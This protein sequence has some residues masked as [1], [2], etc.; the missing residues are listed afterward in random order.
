MGK[1]A[2]LLGII[3]VA[4]TGLIAYTVVY[5]PSYRQVQLIQVKEAKEQANQRAQADAVA[6]LKT[7]EAYRKRL[8]SERN[9]SWLVRET[10]ALAQ[11]A[12]VQI[13]NI[14]QEEPQSF[15]GFSRLTVSLQFTASYHQLGAFLDQ[16]E[17]SDRFIRVDRVNVQPAGAKDEGTA[18]IKLSFSTI[19]LPPVLR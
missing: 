5:V 11:K 18:T 8:P 16:V 7:V 3:M 6:L 12:G 17:Q 19:Y 14:S 15:A 9:P 10:L 2:L 1:P 13:A 4:M